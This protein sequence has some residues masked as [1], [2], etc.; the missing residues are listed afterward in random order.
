MFE[1]ACFSIKQKTLFFVEEHLPSFPLIVA[2]TY[3]CNLSCG[4]CN[5]RALQHLFPQELSLEDMRKLLGWMKR[6]GFKTIM[7]TGGEPTLHPQFRELVTVCIQRGFDCSMATNGAY[8]DDL[9]PFIGKTIKTIFLNCSTTYARSCQDEL[10]EKLRRLKASGVRLILK[11]NVASPH[12]GISDYC[13]LAKAVGARV[14][15]GLTN[16]PAYGESRA[17]VTDL[18]GRMEA[19]E[20]FARQCCV[21]KVYVYLARPIPRCL[22]THD[23]WKRL[24][25]VLLVKSRCFVGYR[26]N[27]LSRLVVN[28]D[29]STF[30]CF[31]NMRKEENIVEMPT[32]KHLNSTY[33][34][35]F[36]KATGRC[37]LTDKTDCEF[38]RRKECYGVCFAYYTGEE[39]ITDHAGRS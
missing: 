17:V 30:G 26:G 24:R 12:D 28:P 10:L 6:T 20:R 8:P 5:A 37:F 22:Y 33:K 35:H 38:L 1:R 31:N 29:L 13:V 4:Y 36:L 27:Y 21:N 3:R 32:R 39:K 11:I 14:R 18:R 16:P 7:F 25:K 15:I 19:V 23:E 9:G 34:G 2:L